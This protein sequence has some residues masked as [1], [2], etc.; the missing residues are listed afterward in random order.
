MNYYDKLEKLLGYYWVTEGQFFFVMKKKN[1]IKKI[2]LYQDDKKELVEIAWKDIKN[3]NPLELYNN[4]TWEYE[5]RMSVELIDVLEFH[6]VSMFMKRYESVIWF[7][8]SESTIF[9]LKKS[10]WE[11]KIKMYI[12]DNISVV[13]DTFF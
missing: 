1:G 6:S 4:L 12:L 7:K 13:L 11:G 2:N 5:F 3:K 10:K 9:R 8:I